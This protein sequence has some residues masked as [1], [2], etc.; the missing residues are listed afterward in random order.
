M[1][2]S[3]RQYNLTLGNTTLSNKSFQITTQ[4]ILYELHNYTYLLIIVNH[5]LK[6]MYYKVFVQIATT[7]ELRI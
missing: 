1:E 4:T 7:F 2:V 6:R 3:F 5:R